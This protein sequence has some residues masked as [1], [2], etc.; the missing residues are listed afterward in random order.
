MH[1]LLSLVLGDVGSAGG[2]LEPFRPPS[3]AAAGITVSPS[4][5]HRRRARTGT[6]SLGTHDL[7]RPVRAGRAGAP[8]QGEVGLGYVLRPGLFLPRSC[9]PRTKRK[10]SCL[11]YDILTSV[12][13]TSSLN[14]LARILAV[15]PQEGQIAATLPIIIP[16]PKAD[17]FPENKVPLNAFRSAIRTCKRLAISYV[18]GEGHRTQKREAIQ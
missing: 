3:R 7:P 12:A 2:I 10:P 6:T 8:V 15:L 11:G 17:G 13:T 1:L 14:A 5:R 4:S 9:S 18:N 16:G